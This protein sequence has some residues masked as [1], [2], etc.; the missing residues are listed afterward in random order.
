MRR[1]ASGVKREVDNRELIGYQETEVLTAERRWWACNRGKCRPLTP[2]FIWA[3]SCL[4]H[5]TLRASIPRVPKAYFE[6]L[7]FSDTNKMQILP[8]NLT[9]RGSAAAFVSAKAGILPLQRGAS[10]KTSERKRPQGAGSLCS[11]MCFYTSPPL[12]HGLSICCFYFPI[13]F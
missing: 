13:T 6:R 5:W 11:V 12:P 10:E 1:R 9:D 3:L 7:H 2:I 8:N 4:C